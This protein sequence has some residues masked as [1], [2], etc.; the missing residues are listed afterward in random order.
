MAH[1]PMALASLST[2][3]TSPNISQCYVT[4][5]GLSPFT[6]TIAMIFV[7]SGWHKILLQ[8][9][10]SSYRERNVSKRLLTLLIWL[11]C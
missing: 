4:L 6:S 1:P 5:S 7:Q 2:L 3:S 10:Y 11:V 9:L 8:T